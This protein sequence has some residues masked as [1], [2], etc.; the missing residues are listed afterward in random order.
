[1]GLLLSVGVLL[2]SLSASTATALCLLLA[3]PYLIIL[4]VTA[5]FAWSLA[6]ILASALWFAVPPL[7]SSAAWSLWLAV[8]AQECARLAMYETF[9]YMRKIG[10]GVEAFVRP[11]RAN[12]LLSGLAVGLGFSSMSVLVNFCAVVADSYMTRTAVYIPSCN[13]INFFVAASALSL[14]HSVLH[15]CWGAVIWPL[16]E[17]RQIRF[18]WGG[19]ALV[20][21]G[22]L[23]AAL[24][25][26]TSA[27][28]GG[29]IVSLTV[30][31]VEVV[32]AVILVG[33]FSR[34]YLADRIRVD[35]GSEQVRG[36][37]RSRSS[38][39]ELPH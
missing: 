27:N 26:L 18:K 19:C 31:W 23:F 2:L 15:L 10:E 39:G 20:Y 1:M 16:Y 6:M 33:L 28:P 36:P 35:T 30:V 7:K 8:S 37:N 34:A 9:A 13:Q 5:A 12:T 25:G 4:A 32:L 3:K 24:I 14:A 22:H 38:I 21:C 29:C 11:G 17:S